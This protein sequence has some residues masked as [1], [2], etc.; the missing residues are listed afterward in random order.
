MSVGH[1]EDERERLC[2]LAPASSSHARPTWPVEA[3]N[4]RCT[5]DAAF[6]ARLMQ[7]WVRLTDEGTGVLVFQ[8]PVEEIAPRIGRQL[9]TEG[10]KV[11]ESGHGDEPGLFGRQ[12]ASGSRQGM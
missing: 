8:L 6:P 2:W 11:A 9:V 1:L 10:G 4:D 5:A 3:S 12:L 7:R